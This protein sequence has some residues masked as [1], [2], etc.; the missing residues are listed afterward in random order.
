MKYIKTY[1]MNSYR[2]FWIVEAKFFYE[3]AKFLKV[4][5][6]TYR[7]WNDDLSED[8]PV[9]DYITKNEKAIIC[10]ELENRNDNWGWGEYED[11]DW[12][13]KE[14]YKL[15]GELKI[16]NGEVI[17]DTFLPDIKNYNL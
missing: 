3:I 10:N 5:S 8:N 16:E 17:L 1:E 2:K 6:I 9:Y 4:D 7:A 15:Q 14:N 11:F 13:I 12:F